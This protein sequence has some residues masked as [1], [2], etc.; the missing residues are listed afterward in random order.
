MVSMKPPSGRAATSPPGRPKSPMA[1][2]SSVVRPPSPAVDLDVVDRTLLQL[3]RADARQSQ[4]ELARKI[5]MSAPAIAERISR[6]ER[7]GVIRAYRAEVDWSAIGLPMLLFVSITVNPGVELTELLDDLGQLEGLQDLQFVTGG[8][9][10]IARLRLRDFAHMHRVML[11]Q[12][13]PINGIQRVET[14]IS[15]GDAPVEDPISW[16]FGAPQGED[17][18]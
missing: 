17:E 15:L 10:L 4:R 9:D 11:D 18:S 3:L 5:G 2:V 16:L 14:I 6:L 7:A 1:D 8:S 12:L 13:W